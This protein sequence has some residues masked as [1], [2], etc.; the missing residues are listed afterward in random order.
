MGCITR[1]MAALAKRKSHKG[2]SDDFLQNKKPANAGVLSGNSIPSSRTNII[3]ETGTFH[4]VYS[5]N[6]ECNFHLNRIV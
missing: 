4:S 6:S 2:K 3:Q 5:Y 1:M